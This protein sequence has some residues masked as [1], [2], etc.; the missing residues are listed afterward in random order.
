MCWR[1]SPFV[2]AQIWGT[3]VSQ[4][5]D[6]DSD[7]TVCYSS[8]HVHVTTVRKYQTK[9]IQDQRTLLR[10]NLVV[11]DTA[12]NFGHLNPGTNQGAQFHLEQPLVS[13]ANIDQF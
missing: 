3:P 10:P 7:N 6:N 11:T 2:A 8:G 5:L 12:L 13:R 4:D 9:Y 1:G